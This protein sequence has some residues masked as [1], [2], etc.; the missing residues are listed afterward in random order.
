MAFY[1]ERIQT[2]DTDT[3]RHGYIDTQNIKKL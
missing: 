2:W 3:A 1:V